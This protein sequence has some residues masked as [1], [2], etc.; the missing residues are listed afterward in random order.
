MFY[1]LFASGPRGMGETPPGYRHQRQACTI[2][3]CLGNIWGYQKSLL[4]DSRVVECEDV[5][6]LL[7]APLMIPLVCCHI[8][9]FRQASRGGEAMAR[10]RKEGKRAGI[11]S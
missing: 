7:S 6:S 4:L 11:A 1:I 3:A 5:L 9:S 8:K 10:R 2:H